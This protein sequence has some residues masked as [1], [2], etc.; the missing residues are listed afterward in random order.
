MESISQVWVASS[1][2]DSQTLVGSFQIRWIPQVF[3]LSL[4]FLVFV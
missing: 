2:S 1:I 4:S 3:F